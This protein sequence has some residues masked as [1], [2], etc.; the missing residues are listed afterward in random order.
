MS[1]LKNEP[2]RPESLPSPKQRPG[3]D[4][5]IFD[6]KCRFCRS[7]VERLDRLDRAGRLAFL[8]LH[9]PAVAEQYSDLSHDALMEEMYVIDARGVRRRGAE[10]FRYL[11]R[12]LP[13]LWPLA[14]ILHIPFSLPLWRWLYR[15]VA[16]R[17][18]RLA[19]SNACDDDACQIHFRK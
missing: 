9:D 13:L 4:V 7:Q 10:A 11:S 18:Y 17:R 14:P 8:S 5:V 15:Q 1:T 6:G 2:A 16:S 12:R 3:A 19:G